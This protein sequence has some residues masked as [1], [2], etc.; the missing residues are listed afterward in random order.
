MQKYLA[1][2][3]QMENTWR[4]QSGFVHQGIK[5]LMDSLPPPPF[6]GAVIRYS[7]FFF[8]LWLSS[9][10]KGAGVY[11]GAPAVQSIWWWLPKCCF[12]STYFLLSSGYFQVGFR[13]PTIRACCCFCQLM[14]GSQLL[15]QS[16]M[17]CCGFHFICTSHSPPLSSGNG[18]S[19]IGKQS[20]PQ[21]ITMQQPGC[22]LPQQL[23]M[24]LPG[25]NFSL[26]K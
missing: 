25:W 20:L 2:T 21:N 4:A 22:G 15:H 23:N 10:S 24:Q 5:V 17:I 7:I 9:P 26:F 1:E 8:K 16:T 13:H 12:I 19:F 14:P 6:N 11:L 18:G 3:W